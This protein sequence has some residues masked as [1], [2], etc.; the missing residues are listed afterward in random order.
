MTC[1]DAISPLFTDLYELTMAAGY[2]EHGLN[3]TATF[4]VFTRD[5]LHTRGYF[6]AA[7][8]ETVLRAL[9]TLRFS[10]DDL[11]YLDTLDQF[12]KPFLDYLEAFRFSGSVTAMPEG[13]LFFPEEPILEIT[14]PMIESQ[15][16]ETFVLNTVG[17]AS[18]IA[19]KAAR[20]VH[21]AGDR[22]LVDFS[23]RRTQGRDA[24][25]QVARS[26]YVAGFSATSN[27]EAGK[28]LGIPVS[29]TMAHSFVTAFPTELEAFRAFAATFPDHAVFLVDTY[30]TIEGAKNAAVVGREMVSRGEHP[31]GVRLDSGDMGALSREVRTILDEA[32]LEEMKI[33]AS[34]GFDEFKI[35][36]VLAS[37]APIDAFGVGTSMGVS[38]DAPFMDIVYKLVRFDGRNIRKLS[39]GKTTLAGEKQVFRFLDGDGAMHHDV[40]ARRDES[41]TGGR[42]LLRQVM[43]N[44][45][46]LSAPPTLEDIRNRFDSA[47]GRLPA[48]YKRLVDPEGFPVRL[49]DALSAIQ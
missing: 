37:D 21:A 1:N 40:I 32:G 7:G 14:A 43:G 19:S 42:P 41:M 33:F 20:C 5:P 26:S 29:G 15:I 11:D 23:L 35:D 10:G 22:S 6:V 36:R 12:H 8:L 46:P 27:V 4:S 28:R 48:P 24:G 34:S 38:A 30:D 47:F 16:A 45:R 39:P 18:M 17:L 2:F 49:S 13:T 9:E 3:R 31:V 25:F 44:G